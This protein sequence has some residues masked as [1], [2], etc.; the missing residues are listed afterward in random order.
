MFVVDKVTETRRIDNSQT[1]LDAILLNVGVD[2]LDLDGL[3]GLMRELLVLFGRVELG[4]EEGV[5]E[6]RFAETRLACINGV[7]LTRVFWILSNSVCISLSISLSSLLFSFLLSCFSRFSLYTPLLLPLAPFFF[8][9]APPSVPDFSNPP[10]QPPESHNGFRRLIVCPK[11]EE[12]KRDRETER[13]RQHALYVCMCLKAQKYITANREKG[14]DIQRRERDSQ[15]RD[16][17]NER[18]KKNRKWT[19]YQQPYR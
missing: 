10:L 1:Q 12:G 15:S 4:V 3:R 2:G 5:D 8:P 13:Q 16:T 11:N 17:R 6:G 9:R 18:E 19:T 14:I 7:S